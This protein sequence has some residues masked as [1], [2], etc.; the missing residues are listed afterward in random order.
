M[1]YEIIKNKE[2]INL[3]LITNI[4]VSDTRLI[5]CFSDGKCHYDFESNEKAVAKMHEIKVAYNNKGR[6]VLLG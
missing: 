6:N 2:L 4:I 1:M 5:V 3:S